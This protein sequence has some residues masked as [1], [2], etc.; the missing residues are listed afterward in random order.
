MSDYYSI[1]KEI[2]SPENLMK[3]VDDH[4]FRH[5][6]KTYIPTELI[7]RP[8]YY[9]GHRFKPINPHTDIER[10]IHCGLFK[11]RI[12]TIYGLKTYYATQL[13]TFFGRLV[14]FETD[15]VEFITCNEMIIKSI[16]E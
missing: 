14:M 2:Y 12:N 7:S 9:T 16:I 3:F 4:Q 11:R 5:A 13:N 15:K 10:C 6:E 1:L 8:D